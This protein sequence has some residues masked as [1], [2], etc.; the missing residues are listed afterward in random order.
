MPFFDL[1]T[2]QKNTMRLFQLFVLYAFIT[3]NA[4]AQSLT[5]SE[6]SATR[7]NTTG[8]FLVAG[9][10]LGIQ[11]NTLSFGGPSV[12]SD[13]NN[14]TALSAV[15]DASGVALHAGNGQKLFT[16][17]YKLPGN[18]SSVKLYVKPNGGYIIRENIANFLFYDA[19]GKIVQSV[20]NSSQSRE[21]EAISELAADPMYKTVVLYNPKIVRNGKEGGSAQVLKSNWTTSTISY[22][23][24]RA[25]RFVRVSDNGQWIAVISNK[26]GTDD[27]VE[28]T[29][30]YGNLLNTVHFNQQIA[31]VRFSENGQYITLRSGGR[32]AV[33]NMLDGDRV[34]S[35][36]FRSAL[37]FAQYVPQDNTVIALT[38]DPSGSVLSNV[39]VHAIN[40]KARKIERKEYNTALGETELLSLQLKRNGSLHYTILG[41]S[42]QLNVKVRF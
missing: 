10:T 24:D 17:S 23:K 19:N 14:V 26:N 3:V 29:D 27:K 41:L 28:I 42:K 7:S 16:S 38:A 30:R 15:L 20:S 18:D 33:Y 34:G 36:S 35:T 22:H 9:H 39:E 32:A 6:S 4:Q 1:Q 5:I 12:S 2:N 25:I 13:V 31:D 40:L 8:E 21:G 11:G 37:Q